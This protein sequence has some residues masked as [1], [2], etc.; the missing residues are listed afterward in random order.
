MDLTSVS[1]FLGFLSASIQFLTIQKGSVVASL[2]SIV[3]STLLYFFYF[4]KGSQFVLV[5]VY[6]FL[7]SLYMVLF[8]LDSDLN[9]TQDKEEDPSLELSSAALLDQALEK[10]LKNHI[11]GNIFIL[12]YDVKMPK[13]IEKASLK[14]TGDQDTYNNNINMPIDAYPLK[15][16]DRFAK[17]LYKNK[18]CQDFGLET[19]RD[20]LGFLENLEIGTVTREENGKSQ[21]KVAKIDIASK[22]STQRPFFNKL[23]VNGSPNKEII[24]D[25]EEKD[26]EFILQE[27]NKRNLL[28]LLKNRLESMSSL[29]ENEETLTITGN[30]KTRNGKKSL[31]LCFSNF[32]IKNNG[33]LFFHFLE[34]GPDE[35]L[36]NLKEVSK[37]KDQMLANVAHDLRSPISGIIAFIEQSLDPNI[38]RQEHDKLLD[39]AKISAHLLLHL[40]SDILD[41][42]LVKKGKLNLVIKTFSLKET[43]HQVLRL[44]RYQAQL[45]NIHLF[46]DYQPVIDM[47]LQNDD[48]R[49]CQ[50]LTNLLS[51]AIKFTIKGAVC[52]RISTTRYQNILKFEVIDTGIGIRPEIKPHLFKPFNTFSDQKLQNKEGIGLG[53]SICK[54]IVSLLGPSDELYVASEYG[55][56]SKFGFLMFTKVQKLEN[57]S[58]RLNK[59]RMIWDKN[60]FKPVKKAPN[61]EYLQEIPQ[62][63]DSEDVSNSPRL[64]YSVEDRKNLELNEKVDV[65]GF[66]NES[67][68]INLPEPSEHSPDTHKEYVE[69]SKLEIDPANPTFEMKGHMRKVFSLKNLTES[70]IK[71]TENCVNVLIVDDNPFNI[72]ILKNYLKKVNNNN[73]VFNVLSAANGTQACDLFEEYN[74]PYN[75][76]KNRHIHVIFMDCQMPIMSGY[77]ATMNIKEK[78][79]KRGYVNTLVVALTAF[80]NEDVCLECGMDAYLLKPVSEKDFLEIFEVFFI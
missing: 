21:E 64:V 56:G 54:T 29:P 71:L 50:V 42:S 46:L 37:L 27:N 7:L 39:F 77:Q 69:E 68:E 48:R 79:N 16:L 26:S 34:L 62:V 2:G 20:F 44:L 22:A 35:D 52:L 53:L 59:T 60:E 18:R 31:K 23:E 5:F 65:V 57:S 17:L 51:N 74:N 73:M 49:L 12:G 28:L 3:L 45:K 63:E 58:L 9:D 4:I 25:L 14:E 6:Y 38:S 43:M 1:F 33:Y 8:R 32:C 78:I 72:F 41:F 55:K 11:P 76:E 36:M 75:K 30:L 66:F 10:I 47:T 80:S 19:K 70:R 40:V 61:L 13:E 15:G 24:N 67:L